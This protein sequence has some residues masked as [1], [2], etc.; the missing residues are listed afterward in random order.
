MNQYKL[1]DQKDGQVTVLRYEGQ[2]FVPSDP[3]N[4]HWKEYMKYVDNGGLTD[5]MEEPQNDN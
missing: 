5:P 2:L 1:I 4:T 3:G